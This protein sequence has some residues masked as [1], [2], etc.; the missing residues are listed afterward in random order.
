MISVNLLGYIYIYNHGL[1]LFMFFAILLLGIR[2]KKIAIYHPDCCT[3]NRESR[4]TSEGTG[5]TQ[6]LAT[7]TDLR[8]LGDCNGDRR[9][10]V[11]WGV[12]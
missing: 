3:R 8:H 1:K 7:N 6:S 10:I 11:D 9:H 5:H 4:E 2:L 12:L